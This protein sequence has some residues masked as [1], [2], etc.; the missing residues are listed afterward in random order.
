MDGIGTILFDK[1]DRILIESFGQVDGFYTEED[2]LKFLESITVCLT[3]K[4]GQYQQAFHIPFAKR[5]LFGIQVDGHKVTLLSS[6]VIHESRWPCLCV[7][8]LKED[9]LRSHHQ[10]S[11][12]ESHDAD[13]R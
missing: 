2:I 7:H 3:E 12:S 8:I 9:A 11:T 5:C 1:T 13:I 6:F 10:K 4:K